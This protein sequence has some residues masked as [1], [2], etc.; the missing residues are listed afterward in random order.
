MGDVAEVG[1]SPV[2][3]TLVPSALCRPESVRAGFR[4]ATVAQR[5]CPHS[6]ESAVAVRSGVVGVV[7]QLVVAT[8][9]WS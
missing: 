7:P 2:T 6:R 8:G 5:L 1:D 9:S 3:E 4:F